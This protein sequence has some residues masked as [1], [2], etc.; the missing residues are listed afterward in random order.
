M[1]KL[2]L[3]EDDTDLIKK[4]R[5]DLEN[6]KFEVTCVNNSSDMES[7]LSSEKFDV[8]VSDTDL[9]VHVRGGDEV[10]KDLLN[11][12][13]LKDTLII[14]ISSVRDNDECWKGIAHDFR[15][16]GGI[17]DLGKAVQ[18]NYAKYIDALQSGEEPRRYKEFKNARI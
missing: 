1:V 4:Y 15:Y 3:V 2:L 12:G 6:S 13:Y 14:G 11:K 8:I 9:G 17:T 18:S 7:I 5:L 16:K 10:C